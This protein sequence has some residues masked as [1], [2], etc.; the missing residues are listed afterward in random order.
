MVYLRKNTMKRFKNIYYFIRYGSIMKN[1]NTNYKLNV[2]LV[3][4]E[5]I[6]I[7]KVDLSDG[8]YCAVIFND[9]TKMRFWNVNRWYAWM[10]QGEIIFS[11][12]KTLTWNATMPSSEVLYKFKKIIKAQGKI[13]K[14]V[15]SEYSELLPVKVIRK[16]KLDKL[17]KII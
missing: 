4:L 10:S 1:Y 2:L 6:G 3:Y 14:I 13:K 16:R 8:Y 12:G 11:N 17:K 9:N 5:E 15:D 7:R